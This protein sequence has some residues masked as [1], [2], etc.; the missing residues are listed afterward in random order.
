MVVIIIIIIHSFGLLL[1]SGYFTRLYISDFDV[2][3]LTANL[4]KIEL[5]SNSDLQIT[6]L[7]LN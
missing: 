5:N 6:I 3:V 2:D 1:W 4:K 7:T